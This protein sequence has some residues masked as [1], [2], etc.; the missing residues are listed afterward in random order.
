MAP[1]IVIDVLPAGRGDALWIECDTGGSRPWRM[2]VDGGMPDTF[3]VLRERV[4]ELDADDRIIDLAVVSHID[5]DHIGG[6]LALLTAAADLGVQFGDVWFNGLSQLPESEGVQSRS[7]RE[8]ESLVKLLS[9]A[10]SV[11]LPWNVA[12]GGCAAMTSGDAA[13]ALVEL[14]A[15]PTITLLS[16][17][18][19][20]LIALRKTWD[21]ALEGVRRGVAPEPPSPPEPPAPL[22]D[23]E[24]L[25]ATPTAMD[26][27][28]AN[29]SSIAFL[30]EHRGASALFAADAFVPVLGAALTTLANLRGGQPVH[31]DAF[32]LS[33]H[34]SKANV[35]PE[36]LTLAPAD[37][38]VV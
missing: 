10:G 3:P 32:K 19:C 25:A 37:R 11:P 2:I 13:I 4:L 23:L 36:L 18:P 22:D 30:L 28:R 5:A 16:P 31:L 14:G 6:L 17:T 38:Y 9:G 8:G 7:F 15:A 24:A 34:G 21:A 12:F 20:R 26:G 33:H 1:A 27:S 29:G 35:T